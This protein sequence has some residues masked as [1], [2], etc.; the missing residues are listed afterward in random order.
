MALTIGS[1]WQISGNWNLVGG[2]PAGSLFI[3][4]SGD[5]ITTISG[6][7]LITL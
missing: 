6:D 1:G 5:F 3:T 4:L 2:P 7:N